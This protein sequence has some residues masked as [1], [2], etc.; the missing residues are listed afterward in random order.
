MLKW[1]GGTTVEEIMT[2]MGWLKHTTRA[3]LAP[4]G[5]SQRSRGW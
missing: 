4:A 2:A 5:R 1:D 3:M